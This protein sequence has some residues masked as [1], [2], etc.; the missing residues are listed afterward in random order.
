MEPELAVLAVLR[1]EFRGLTR[2]RIV[3]EVGLRGIEVEDRQL[4]GL[5]SVNAKSMKKRQ[6]VRNEG[7]YWFVTEEGKA[8]VKQHEEELRDVSPS[9]LAISFFVWLIWLPFSREASRS[10]RKEVL[11]RSSAPA[12]KTPS[13]PPLRVP[14]LRLRRP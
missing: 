2:Q 8:H 12:T 7:K 1:G 5:L 10:S 11:P 6:L 3:T 9:V 13:P 4:Y 14:L